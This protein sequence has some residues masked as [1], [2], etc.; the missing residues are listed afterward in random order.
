MI[1]STNLAARAEL[2]PEE[3]R[4]A[5]EEWSNRDVVRETARSPHFRASSST[6]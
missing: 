6:V 1:D 4:K 5:M 3:G 2:A